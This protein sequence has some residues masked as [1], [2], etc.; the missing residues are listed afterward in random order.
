M[1]NA[2][3]T[4]DR[5]GA[6]EYERHLQGMDAS[7]RQKVAFTAAHLLCEGNLT[8]MGMGSGSGMSRWIAFEPNA[9]LQLNWVPLAQLVRSR[10]RLHDGHLLTLALRAAHTLT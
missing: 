7:M 4:Q 8:D 6:A 9:P 3:E 5:G 2:Y 1:Q 10:G